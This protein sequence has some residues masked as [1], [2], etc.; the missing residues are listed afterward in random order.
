MFNEAYDKTR[1]EGLQVNVAY[2][3][4]RANAAYNV[5]NIVPLNERIYDTIPDIK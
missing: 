4:I 5:P 3:T 2:E 1:P